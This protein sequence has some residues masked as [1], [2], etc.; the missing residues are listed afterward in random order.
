MSKRFRWVANATVVVAMFFAVGCTPTPTTTESVTQA[1]RPSIQIKVGAL[2][3]LSGSQAAQGQSSLTA[4]QLAVTHVNIADLGVQVELVTADSGSAERDIALAG[5]QDLISQGITAVVG[6]RSSTKVL[7]TYEA[8]SEAGVIQISPSATL[9]G[10]SA[11]ESGGYFFRTA[12]SDIVQATVLA[13]RILFD[14]AASV[15]IITMTD[16]YSNALAAEATNELR[17]AGAD[18]VVHVVEPGDT[19]EAAAAAA[20]NSSRDA[21]LI[22]SSAGDFRSVVDALESHK[23][24]WSNVY[25][26]DAT[27]EVLRGNRSGPQIEGAL[28]STAGVLANR[29]L[30]QAM[31]GINPQVNVFAYAPEVYD[32]LMVIALAA[33]QAQSV[34]GATLRNH[35][36]DVSG[37]DGEAVRTFEQA[38]KLINAGKSIDYN[39]L[40]GPIDFD[41]NG[42]LTGAFISFYLYGENN[43]V[44]WLDQK[45]WSKN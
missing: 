15:D 10:L 25:G 43:S 6:P 12:P 29:D 34:D 18:V 14:G 3:P 2:L 9:P 1:P 44:G 22:V 27:I 7:Q 37:P 4:I 40:S 41:E 26:T 42:D 20:V 32:A 45:F 19:P 17:R 5:A 8:F 16:A 39:G 30:Q 36:I 13:R 31:H 38:A 28:F 11:V 24:N 33:L 23:V 21:I 35:I